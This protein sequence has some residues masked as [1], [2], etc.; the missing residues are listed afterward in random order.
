MTTIQINLPDALAE[1]ASQAGLLAPGKIESLL[2]E[3]L[4]DERVGRMRT[5]RV[6][7]AA[8]PIPAMTPSEIHDEIEAY[9]IAQRGA[10]GS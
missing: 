4:R 7:L 10:T 8:E 2:R 6:L 3:C 1:E 9:R 5:A